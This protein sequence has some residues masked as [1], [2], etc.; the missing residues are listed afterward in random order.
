MYM[1]FYVFVAIASK[2]NFLTL[3]DM[4]PITGSAAVMHRAV[5]VHNDP[6]DKLWFLSVDCW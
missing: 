1:W 6:V 3:V 4:L 5:R 2:V